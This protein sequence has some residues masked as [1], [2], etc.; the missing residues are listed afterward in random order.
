[1]KQAIFVK[2]SVPLQW[3][4][5]APL[6]LLY[7]NGSCFIGIKDVFWGGGTLGR[8]ANITEVAG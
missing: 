1:M 7:Y 4:V 5:I 3:N 2:R 8:I 6:H